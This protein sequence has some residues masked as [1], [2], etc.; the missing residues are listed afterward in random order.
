MKRYPFNKAYGVTTSGKVFSYRRGIFLKEGDNGLG[1]KFVQI[2]RGN[3]V[4]VHR[5]VA[6]TFLDAPLKGFEVN[7]IDKNKS[8]NHLDNLE[9]VTHSQNLLHHYN[10]PDPQERFNRFIDSGIDVDSALY[11]LN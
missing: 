6:Q 1:Y 9:L 3:I 10:T 5:I 2:G 8:N 7:H 11:A 4:Y